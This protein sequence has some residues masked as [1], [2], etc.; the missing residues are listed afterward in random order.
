ML[1]LQI[2][3]TRATVLRASCYARFENGASI[4]HISY[5]PRSGL[6]CTTCAHQ[7]A[8]CAFVNYL[9]LRT[10]PTLHASRLRFTKPTSDCKKFATYNSEARQHR[11]LIARRSRS[12]SAIL[13]SDRLR[14]F[15]SC[16]DALW[17]IRFDKMS[18]A[19]IQS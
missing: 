14:G 15:D 18:G 6:C 3:I 1:V 19:W 5:S 13:L 12:E 10:S 17:G 16:A 11:P 2:A 8:T 9:Q 4:Q 7:N